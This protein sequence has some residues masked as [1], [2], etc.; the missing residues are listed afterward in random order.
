MY[1]TIISETN[2]RIAVEIAI[3]DASKEMFVNPIQIEHCKA[4][5]SRYIKRVQS[6]LTDYQNYDN[7]VSIRAMK[8]KNEFALRTFVIPDFEDTIARTAVALVIANE[9]EP[10]LIDNCFANRRGDQIK[11]NDSL[12]E[13]FAEHGWHKFST[14][15][16]EAAD[17]YAMLL[18]TDLSSFYD[19]ISH[20]H[21][22]NSLMREFLLKKDDPIVI[23]LSNM[24]RIKHVYSAS[25]EPLEVIHGITIGPLGNQI[26]SNL[27]L[28]QIDHILQTF[29]GVEYGRYVDDIRIFGNDVNTIKHALNELQRE[30][31][32]IGL[33]INGAKTKYA[34]R[35]D[36]LKRLIS[37]KM[38]SYT[39]EED[40]A[41]LRAPTQTEVERLAR[42]WDQYQISKKNEI[43]K[44]LH[45]EHP[46]LDKWKKVRLSGKPELV[47]K[48]MH[49]VNL[50]FDDNPDS[51]TSRVE[52]ILIK[53]LVEDPEN[54][55]FA[56]WLLARM[57]LEPSI[58]FQRRMRLLKMILEMMNSLKIPSYGICR[59]L[60]FLSYQ[61]KYYRFDYNLVNLILGSDLRGLYKKVLCRCINNGRLI[62][63]VIGLYALRVYNDNHAKQQAIR[64]KLRKDNSNNTVWDDHRRLIRGI[65]L[66]VQNKEE[67]VSLE[68]ITSIVNLDGIEIEYDDEIID[69]NMAMKIIVPDSIGP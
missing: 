64:I 57:M 69:L 33:N 35:K 62:M 36:L 40:L 13:S 8:R 23:L 27:I 41:S 10:K 44:P 19:S 28:N 61:S 29:P 12:T 14:W 2:I 20:E 15:Q 34:G 25:D 59:I 5:K 54:E 65:P 22:I 49:S 4:H 39:V 68:S 43:D 46:S 31:Y 56:A 11:H 17:K 50:A 26:L 21:L 52:S 6:R 51:L 38:L 48:Y 47:K 16:A 67:A 1:E 45:R 42:D 7:L 30:L 18:K 53:A 55:R 24:L 3:H 32:N 66:Q 63:N 58:P 9:L 60:Y 37:E